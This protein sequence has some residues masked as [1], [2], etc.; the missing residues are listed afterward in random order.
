MPDWPK[1]MAVQSLN[2]MDFDRMAL[3]IATTRVNNLKRLLGH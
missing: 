3:A 2:Q 1:A